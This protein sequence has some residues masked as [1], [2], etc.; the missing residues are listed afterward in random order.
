MICSVPYEKACCPPT[1][2]LGQGDPLICSNVRLFASCS[3]ADLCAVAQCEF[4]NSASRRHLKLYLALAAWQTFQFL[5]QDHVFVLR[6]AYCV[7][8]IAQ[9]DK[10]SSF[11]I[12][13]GTSVPQ[14]SHRSSRKQQHVMTR[15][16]QATYPGYHSER[17]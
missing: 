5:L 11:N 10:N 15:S 8:R 9:S 16:P 4:R 17:K 12:R 3:L 2:F 6:I 13:A 14:A 7:L 1:L